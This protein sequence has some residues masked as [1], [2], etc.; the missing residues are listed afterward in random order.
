MGDRAGGWEGRG[1]GLDK[2]QHATGWA[3]MPCFH[4]RNMTRTLWFGK[5]HKICFLNTTYYY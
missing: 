5:R 3:L 4:V 1:S 2:A